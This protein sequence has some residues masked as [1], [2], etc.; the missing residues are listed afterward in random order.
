[1]A[2]FLSQDF[3]AGHFKKFEIFFDVGATRP[4]AVQFWIQAQTLI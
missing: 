1:L 3:E 2:S 4:S